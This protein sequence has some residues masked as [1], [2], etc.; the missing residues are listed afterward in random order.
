[1][2]D[3]SQSALKEAYYEMLRIRRTQHLHVWGDPDAWLLGI[4]PFMSGEVWT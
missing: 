3:V 2:T 4:E 1:M